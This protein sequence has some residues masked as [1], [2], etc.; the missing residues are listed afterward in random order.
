MNFI[1]V[2]AKFQVVFLEDASVFLDSIEP[3]ARTKMFYNIRKA[4]VSN[5]ENL[6]KKLILGI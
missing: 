5:N 2:K 4:Q 6:F 3:R 1:L